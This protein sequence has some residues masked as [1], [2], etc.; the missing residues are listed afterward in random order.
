M[1][2]LGLIAGG[3][4]LPAEIAQRCEAAGRPYFVIRLK[5]FADEGT[6]GHPSADIGLAELGKCFKA[7][8]AER[9]EVICF[10]GT[11]ARPDFAKLVPDVRGLAALPG[12]IA[13]ARH[14]DDALLRRLLEE[15]RKEGFEIEG[16]HEAAG[17]M[18]LPLGLLGKYGPSAEHVADM[19]RAL[20]VARAIGRL[21]VG[22][23]AVVCNGLVLAVEAQEGTDMMLR[24]VRELPEALRGRPEH[25]RGVLAK[26]PKPIQEVRVDL[27]TIGVATVRGAAQAGLAGIVGEMG[28]LLIVDRQ[29]TVAMADDLGLFI[30]GVEPLSE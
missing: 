27:P 29:E 4:G 24:R 22:Q 9:C 13:A 15:F 18:T 19:E 26:A 20:T 1:R 28:R 21:D 25:L 2:K 8:K 5:G 3:G 14:G 6:L 10:A 17:S 23:G 16:A 30:I 7:L 11:V 12:V